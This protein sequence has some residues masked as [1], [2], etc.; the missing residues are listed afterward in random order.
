M[1]PISLSIAAIAI[2]IYSL[3]K[4]HL[5]PFSTL[6]VAGELKLRVYPIK[7]ANDKWFIATFILP[8]SVTNEGARPGIIRGLRLRLHFPKVPIPKNHE[9]IPASFETTS[10]GARLVDKNRFQWIDKVVTG[11]WMPFVVLP[12]TTISKTLMFETRWEDAVVQELVECTLEIST[13]E[14]CWEPAATWVLVLDKHVWSELAHGAGFSFHSKEMGTT[15]PSCAPEDLHKYTG[16]KEQ[17]P[18]EGFAAHSSY[19]D[20]PDPENN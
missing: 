19:L 15:L 6:A 5:A 4:T 10:D 7:N 16:T 8:I 1:L 20:F 9:L 18:K 13:R 14:K 17:I 3:W 11:G 12:K 2:S